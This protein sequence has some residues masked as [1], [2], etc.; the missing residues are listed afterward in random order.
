MRIYKTEKSWYYVIDIGRDPLTNARR[1]KKKGGF[2]TKKEAEAAARRTLDEVAHG[3]VVSNA[4]LTFRQMAELWIDIYQNETKAKPSTMLIRSKQIKRWLNQFD[5]IKLSD[6][7][8]KM[9][10]DA[11]TD[12]HE[13]YAKNTL[14]GMVNTLKMIFKKA[15]A[16]QYTKNNPTTFIYLPKSKKSLEESENEVADMKYMEKETLGTFLETAKKF[17]LDHDY[18]LFLLLSYSGMRIGEALALKWQDIDYDEQI[19]HIRRTLFY[20]NSSI[21]DYQLITPKTTTSKRSIIVDMVVLAE[22]K[23]MIV[24]QKEMKLKRRDVH[25]QGFIFTSY[26]KMPGYPCLRITC[27]R[28]L[29]RLL[30]LAE[31]D[32]PYT[33][34]SF[35]H[36]HTSLLAEAGAGLTEIME[37]LGHKD[38]SI[39]RDIYLHVTKQ[40]KK[41][42]SDKFSALMNSVRT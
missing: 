40:L 25:D 11:L 42:A 26:H 8:R 14:S 29:Q 7:S 41:D 33:L 3:Q 1:Q 37:R 39:T 20:P 28:R 34:H 21:K 22:I 36:T 17:G 5:Q 27:T 18:P 19:V 16:L 4:S 38:D 23:K 13:R 2:R 10:Q 31:I 15:M 9:I 24:R 35:R 12:F 30:K 32:T 6:I